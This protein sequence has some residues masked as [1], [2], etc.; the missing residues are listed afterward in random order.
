MGA[1]EVP[2]LKGASDLHIALQL[3]AGGDT[4]LR[5]APAEHSAHH[6]LRSGTGDGTHVDDAGIHS[7]RLLRCQDVREHVQILRIKHI[8]N[9][10]E[11]CASFFECVK[12]YRKCFLFVYF[13]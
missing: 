12:T 3:L 2:V 8:A 6:H 5:T 1:H 10:T 11:D 9:L 4:V 7:W 13:L